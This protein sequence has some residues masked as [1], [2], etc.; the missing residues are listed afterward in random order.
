M[1]PD[2]RLVHPTHREAQHLH[3]LLQAEYVGMYGETDPNPDGGFEG[4]V[5]PDGGVLLG[6]TPS[7]L[8]GNAVALG[9]WCRWDDETAV[10]KRVYTHFDHRRRGWSRALMEEI[11]RRVR[12][13]GYHRLILETG[14][15]QTHAITM[16]VHLGYTAVE[17][18]G[19]YAGQS[20]SV[21]LGKELH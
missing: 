21:F 4:C 7:E 3:E 13:Q 17:P 5:H 15:A 11:E 2:I 10:L 20:T 16:Y 12:D 1:S 9:A 8:M 18:F 19:F 6:F 14:T